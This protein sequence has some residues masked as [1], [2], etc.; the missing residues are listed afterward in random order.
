[1]KKSSI[2]CDIS[3]GN[4]LKVNRRFG[5]TCQMHLPGQR[6]NQARNQHEVDSKLA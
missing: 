2:F 1:M 5:G 6:V 4:L 3:P